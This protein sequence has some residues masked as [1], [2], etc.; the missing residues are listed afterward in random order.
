MEILWTATNWVLGSFVSQTWHWKWCVCVYYDSK[1]AKWFLPHRFRLWDKFI[2]KDESDSETGDLWPGRFPW[3]PLCELCVCVQDNPLLSLNALSAGL[4]QRSSQTNTAVERK[5]F[6]CDVPPQADTRKILSGG[7]P[8]FH[9]DTHTHITCSSTSQ[10]AFHP[11]CLCWCE[12]TCVCVLW[13][14]L[15]LL[16]DLCVLCVYFLKRATSIVYVYALKQSQR[17]HT[18]LQIQHTH[19]PTLTTPRTHIFLLTVA[20]A[21]EIQLQ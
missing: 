16:R 15:P 12:N 21:V 19:T 4:R 2:G 17:P 7:S 3:R 11:E 8:P 18:H 10:A 9:T 14:R 1:M 13:I 6:H 5:Y 20:Y